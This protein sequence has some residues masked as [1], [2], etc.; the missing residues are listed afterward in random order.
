[1]VGRMGFS[2]VTGLR[3]FDIPEAAGHLDAYRTA[4]REAGHAGDGNVYLRIPVYVAATAAKAHAE[5]EEST[6]RSYRRLAENFASSVGAAGTTGSEERA[7]RAERLSQLTYDD[8]LRDRVA[9]G[10]PDMVVDR[11]RHLRDVLG[12]SGVIMESNVGGRIPL[13]RV[14]DSIRLYAQEVAPRLRSDAA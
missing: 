8:V 5:P 2:L 9:Y 1:M 7:E 3:G 13:D 11:L 4:L 6:M 14:L 10:T 12:L